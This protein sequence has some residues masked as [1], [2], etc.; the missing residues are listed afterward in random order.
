MDNIIWFK[1]N[2]TENEKKK[3]NSTDAIK[4]LLVTTQDI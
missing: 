1:L 3:N 4:Y 2:E